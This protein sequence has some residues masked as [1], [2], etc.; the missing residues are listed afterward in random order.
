MMS[1][2]LFNHRLG[3][4]FD[5]RRFLAI[6]DGARAQPASKEEI[7]EAAAAR[8]KML[9]DT[10]AVLET[11][12]AVRGTVGA[13]AASGAGRQPEVSVA[14]GAVCFCARLPARSPGA[15]ARALEAFHR[16]GVEVL[17]ATVGRHGH[18]AG[19][20]VLT[21]TAAA[22]PPEVLEMIRAGIAAIY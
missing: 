3:V 11:Y 15:L 4:L 10:V 5:R 21:V 16:R 17:V 14:V 20:A 9:E 13:G 22:A 2:F 7:V 6:V 8:V 18:G 19:A 12:R 1:S